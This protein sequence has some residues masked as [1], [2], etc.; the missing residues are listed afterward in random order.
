MPLECV[1]YRR[2]FMIQKKNGPNNLDELKTHHT[3]TLASCNG[4]SFPTLGFYE[5]RYTLL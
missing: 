5:G 3:P 1:T 2:E 4:I